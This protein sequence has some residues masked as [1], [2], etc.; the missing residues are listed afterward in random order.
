VQPALFLFP[1]ACRLNKRPTPCNDDHP[2]QTRTLTEG[3]AVIVAGD[4]TREL[5]PCRLGRSC[6]RVCV[7]PDFGHVH[8][9]RI[10]RKPYILTISQ[11]HVPRSRIHIRNN[12]K[13]FLQEVVNELH[14]VLF[15]SLVFLID[16]ISCIE[17]ELDDLRRLAR[18]GP[19]PPHL[20]Q[21][22]PT[23]VRRRISA[24]ENLIRTYA[25]DEQA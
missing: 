13:H 5:V 16:F 8:N 23:P 11:P 7:R 1:D 15:T 14:P 25:D 22:E 2:Q 21:A 4:I 6:A 24:L 10:P 9:P 17:H 18:D 20:L 19:I 12:H 3:D